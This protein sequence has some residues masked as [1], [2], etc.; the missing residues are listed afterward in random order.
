MACGTDVTAMSHGNF[1]LS[2]TDCLLN[3]GP[4]KKRCLSPQGCGPL[5]QPSIDEKI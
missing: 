5:G 2:D 4:L 1:L 3:P